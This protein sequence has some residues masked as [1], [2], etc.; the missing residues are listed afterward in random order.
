MPKYHHLEFKHLDY[1]FWLRIWQTVCP[2]SLDPFHSKL[3][4]K[5]GLVFLDIQYTNTR[6][7]QKSKNGDFAI[8][9]SY[10]LS[11][12]IDETLWVIYFKIMVMEN[13]IE[14]LCSINKNQSNK[15]IVEYNLRSI[16]LPL[17]R[18]LVKYVQFSCYVQGL[19][20]GWF[21]PD[22]TLKKQIRIG[23]S[24]KKRTRIRP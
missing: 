24:K 2:R 14:Y 23:P 20:S 5:M 17:R 12:K 16:Y 9:V 18:Y 3:L 13:L 7:C 19:G 11:I 21:F 4:Y 8:H 22:P 1:R 15:N 6:W 10:N